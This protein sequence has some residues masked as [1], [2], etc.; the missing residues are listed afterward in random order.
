MKQYVN[1][2]FLKEAGWEQNVLP[3][4]IPSIPAVMTLFHDRILME[5]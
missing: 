1:T 2:V 4:A 5:K 3:A